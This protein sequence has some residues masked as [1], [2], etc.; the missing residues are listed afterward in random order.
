MPDFIRIRLIVSLCLILSAVSGILLHA[1]PIRKLPDDEPE[2]PASVIRKLPDEPEKGSASEKDAK[3]SE[4]PK[5]KTQAE[6]IREITERLDRMI[7]PYR[8]LQRSQEPLLNR[9]ISDEVI[10]TWR[11]I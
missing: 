2:A 10:P 9:S 8:P 1:A 11:L 7:Y 5:E 3:T 6:A 4:K